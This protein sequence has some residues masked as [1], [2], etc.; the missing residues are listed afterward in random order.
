MKCRDPI[1]R[2]PEVNHRESV[3]Q[4]R[5]GQ[6][7]HETCIGQTRHISIAATVL[8]RLPTVSSD[9]KTRSTFMQET[10]LRRVKPTTRPLKQSPDD[11]VHFSLK[12]LLQP[13][14]TLA[15]NMSLGTLSL[16]S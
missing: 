16:I 8:A 12:G 5:S 14:H 3:L 9:E 4:V 13:G 15:L 2:V 1:Y 7:M 6:C 11:I 10:T